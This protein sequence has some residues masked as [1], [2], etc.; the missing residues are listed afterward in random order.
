M[1]TL[2]ERVPLIGW[3]W[4]WL[5]IAGMT[6]DGRDTIWAYNSFMFCLLIVR[7]TCDKLK[8]TRLNLVDGGPRLTQFGRWPSST[9]KFCTLVCNRIDWYKLE[10]WTWIYFICFSPIIAYRQWPPAAWSVP[11]PRA[12][13]AV[14]KPFVVRWKRVGYG[15]QCAELC[16]NGDH[17]PQYGS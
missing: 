15:S 9:V 2:C 13:F 3:W 8:S 11:N 10:V 12:L 17:W 14:H 6:N 16:I 4:V 1:L 5:F 7:R